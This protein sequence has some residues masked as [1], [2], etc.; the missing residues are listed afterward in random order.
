MM[1]A[2]ILISGIKTGMILLWSGAKVD[3]PAGFVLCDG[4]NSTPNLQNRFIIGAG[5][6]YAVDAS[7]GS[8]SHTHD[9]NQGNHYHDIHSGCDIA[10]G[11]DYDDYTEYVDPSITCDTRSHL[12]PY[13]ALCYIMKT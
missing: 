10:A 6:S 1:Q 7:G 13:Y 8:V 11:E 4:T 2:G 3:I 5:D 12:N 9:V